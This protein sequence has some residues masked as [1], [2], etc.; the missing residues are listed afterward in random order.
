M[1]PDPAEILRTHR[2]ITVVGA[3]ATPG[4]VAH[5]VPK[6]MLDHGWDVVPVNPRVTQLYGRPC[7][8]DLASAPKP[9]GL[10][11][12]Y[13]PGPETPPFVAEAIREGASAIWLQLGIVSAESRA[14][15][16]R[17]GIPYIEDACTKIEAVHVTL[18]ERALKR[19]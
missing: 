15:A 19:N 18:D 3:S 1:E 14:L 16:A 2:R 17:A 4:K 9:L 6:Y 11:N 5:N 8:P 13:R 12:L 7:Y 10:V